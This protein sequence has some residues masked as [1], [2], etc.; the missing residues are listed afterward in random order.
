VTR[1]RNPLIWWVAIAGAV[2]A[3][4]LIVVF[5]LED[6]DR[7]A[8]IGVDVGKGLIELLAVVLIGAALKLIA[9]RYQDQQREDAEA[10]QARAV[11]DEQN[12]RFRQDKYD[13]LVESTN[14]LRRVPILI[15]ANRSVK[16]WS[17]QMLEVIDAGL[18]LRTIKH[19]IYSSR[20]L[21]D[22]PFPNYRAVSWLIEAMY[23]YAEWMTEDFADRKK[24][25]S[26]LQ[27]DA[28]DP[29]LS[30]EEREQRQ[31]GVWKGILALRSMSDLRTKPSDDDRKRCREALEQT[32]GPLRPPDSEAERP[33]LP[34]RPSWVLYEEAETLA[35]EL[36]TNATLAPPR[37][38]DMRRRGA[39]RRRLNTRHD[40]WRPSGHT[41]WRNRGAQTS[42]A[43][44][45]MS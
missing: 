36:I 16:T 33:P 42:L 3:A 34:E 2:A 24:E 14:G 35:L 17:E 8:E 15:D 31:E 22:L 5:L 45:A 37:A 19:Q 12:R 1:P 13:R 26:E 29:N 27:R 30:P 44:G 39:P 6:D 43:H 28:E 18:T 32:I 40:Y 11:K 7:R 4:S 41:L 10:R 9:D 20:D 23:G 25:L 38:G 21:D